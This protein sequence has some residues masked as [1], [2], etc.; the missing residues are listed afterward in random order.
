V[1]TREKLRQAILVLAALA[2]VGM[3]LYPPWVRKGQYAGANSRPLA[4]PSCYAPLWK[5]PTDLHWTTDPWF[6]RDDGNKHLQFLID[7][8]IICD[9]KTQTLKY[10]W[11]IEAGIDGMRLLLQ[12]LPVLL[13]AG[14][15]W[16]LLRPNGIGER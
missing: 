9:P 4:L 1:T 7:P 11:S 6:K 12:C 8:E 15:G 13:L 2:V 10:G 16:V 3:M 5:P 14:L